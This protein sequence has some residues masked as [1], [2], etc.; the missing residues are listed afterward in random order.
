MQE[1]EE[2]TKIDVS[3]ET[4]HNQRKDLSMN[5]ATFNECKVSANRL[6]DAMID[7]DVDGVFWNEVGRRDLMP[8][9]IVAIVGLAEVYRRSKTGIIDR[10]EAVQKQKEMY[11]EWKKDIH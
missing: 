7:G 8:C 10:E 4:F 5:G 6:C 1:N 9:D 3:R 2:C 11:E